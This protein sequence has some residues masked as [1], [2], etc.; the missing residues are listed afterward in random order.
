MGTTNPPHPHKS[1]LSQFYKF[2]LHW[3][4]SGLCVV[5]KLLHLISPNSNLW[6]RGGGDGVGLCG[7][8][9][10]RALTLA[11]SRPE[12]VRLS[13][14][15]LAVF[16][17]AHMYISLSLYIY[18]ERERYTHMYYTY[19]SVVHSSADTS[20][21]PGQNVAASVR[22]I[23]LLTLH[24]TNIAWVKLSRKSPMDMRIPP[25]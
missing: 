18:I 25:L 4:S 10:I 24:P 21:I 23:S 5:S 22:P 1:Y 14:S 17:H 2:K 12:R 7:P 8:R 19:S 9:Y 3:T 16:P 13:V 15:S 6:N 20:A 11:P